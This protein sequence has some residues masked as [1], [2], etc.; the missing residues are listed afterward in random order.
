[1][2]RVHTTGE[3]TARLHH[4]VPGVMHGGGSV[5]AGTHEAEFVRD[6]RVHRQD[7]GDLKGM[8]LR[9]DRF[10]GAAN[11][12][13]RIRLHIPEV[14][15]ARRTEVEDH[16]AGLVALFGIHPAFRLQFGEARHREANGTQSARGEEIA[17]RDAITGGDGGFIGEGEHD[18]IKTTL[19]NLRT[20]TANLNG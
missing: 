16:D 20:E 19:L 13:R 7:L 18:E 1:M 10:E 15:L 11:L 8:A 12:A 17:A 6:L 9:A 4:L 14:L 3:K 2:R 5:V